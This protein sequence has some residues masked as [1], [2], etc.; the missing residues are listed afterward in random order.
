MR[1]LIK[2]FENLTKHTQVKV[3]DSFLSGSLERTLFPYRGSMTEG[4]IFKEE[5]DIYLISISSIRKASIEDEEED[6]DDGDDYVDSE[7]NYSDEE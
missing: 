5:D 6:F 7:S 1:K 4:V 3:L 2:S